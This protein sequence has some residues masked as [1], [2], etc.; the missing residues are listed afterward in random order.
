M[1]R[2]M[3]ASRFDAT[4]DALPAIRDLVRNGATAAG[5]DPAT[6]YHLVLAVDEFATNIVLHGYAENGLTGP[7]DVSV[8]QHDDVV[9]VVIEDDAVPFDPSARPLPDDA[10][11]HKPLQERSVGGLGILLAFEGVHE[12]SYSRTGDRNRNEFRVS[13]AAPSQTGAAGRHALR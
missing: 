3:A 1:T 12:H 2:A 5:L 9:R 6:V 8:G 7:I 10:D 4:L 13:R 11:L